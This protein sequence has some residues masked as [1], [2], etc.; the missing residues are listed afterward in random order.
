M[1][2]DVSMKLTQSVNQLFKLFHSDIV[3]WFLVQASLS[4]NII[5]YLH[6]RVNHLCDM[7]G[8]VW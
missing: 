1:I 2:S 6:F 8:D 4:P 3:Y 7:V 5:F